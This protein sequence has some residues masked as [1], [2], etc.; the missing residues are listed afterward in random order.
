M[1]TGQTPNKHK[2][3]ETTNKHKDGQTPN[4]HKGIETTNKHKDRTD[5]QQT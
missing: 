2:G 1:K 5:F 4:K 3:I